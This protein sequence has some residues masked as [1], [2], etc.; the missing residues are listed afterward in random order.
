M[1]GGCCGLLGEIRG[2]YRHEMATR[3]EDQADEPSAVAS[4]NDNSEVAVRGLLLGETRDL[5][6]EPAA[7][8][9]QGQCGTGLLP[10]GAVDGGPVL[11]P[12]SAMPDG[13]DIKNLN[14][15]DP[16]QAEAAL[17]LGAEA[18]AHQRHM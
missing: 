14:R 7:G 18:P 1:F 16:V 4:L 15:R 3:G 5:L 8:R 2:L 17:G 12:W 13:R 10:Y 11:S 6:G 9:A